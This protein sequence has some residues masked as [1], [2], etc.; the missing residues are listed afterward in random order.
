MTEQTSCVQHQQTGFAVRCGRIAGGA[1]SA[2]AL[3]S[4]LA[5]CGGT[6]DTAADPA[7]TSSSVGGSPSGGLSATGSP[8][9]ASSDS[10]QPSTS[11]PVYLVGDSPA[12]PRLY[13]SSASVPK[14]APLDG[15]VQFLMHGTPKDPDYRSSYQAGAF[16]DVSYDKTKG[17]TVVLTDT[18]LEQAGSLSKKDAM[19]AVQQLVYT[20]EAAEGTTNAPVRIIADG[21]PVRLFGLNTVDG[22]E[23]V[24][25]LDVL[26]LVNV[27]SPE[28][29]TEVSD[30]FTANGL[31]S[32]A[33][34]TVPWTLT[35]H[36]GKVVKK[37]FATA[38][39]WVDKLYPWKATVDVSGLAPGSYTFT[40][41]TDD[42]SGGTEGKGPSTDTKTITVS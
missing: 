39:G 41:S 9:P 8:V 10:P 2:L 18:S 21:A 15:A 13:R 42:P 37:G 38:A 32:S 14:A 36:S 24:D 3:L 33:E 26:N 30:A 7:Q 19:I 35:D 5:A 28:Q 1:L 31:A 11:V 27:L 40:A 4:G 17:F 20:L 16:G 25:E 22:L 6:D 29:G 23:P 12:G 34:A